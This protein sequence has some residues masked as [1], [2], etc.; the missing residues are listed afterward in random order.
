VSWRDAVKLGHVEH[1]VHWHA[2]PQFTVGAVADGSHVAWQVLH[3]H[4]MLAPLQAESAL[5]FR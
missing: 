5:Q 4:C 2:W 3:P 1:G